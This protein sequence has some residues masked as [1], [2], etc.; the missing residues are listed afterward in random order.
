LLWQKD[1]ANVLPVSAAHHLPLEERL[2]DEKAEGEAV[3]YSTIS[4]IH[5]GQA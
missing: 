4:S 3:M 2:K 5:M 1:L